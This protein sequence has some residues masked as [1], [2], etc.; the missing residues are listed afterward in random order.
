MSEIKLIKQ[1]IKQLT[2]LKRKCQPGSKERLD[3]GHKIKE[4]KADILKA[5]IVEPGKEKLIKEIYILDPLI[6]KM[7]MDLNK[8]TIKELEYHIKKL[9]SRGL[10][11]GK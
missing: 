1:Q 7:E 8:F 11:N 4:L 10:T 5:G 9:K 3:L 6:L 2:K